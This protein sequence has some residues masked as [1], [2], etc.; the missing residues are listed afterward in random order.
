MGDEGGRRPSAA[1]SA[2][3]GG[4][5]ELPP[6]QGI[7]HRTPSPFPA[8]PQA[9]HLA[10]LH[11]HRAGPNSAMML[12]TFQPLFSLPL[13][14]EHLSP[15]Y[16]RSCSGCK[17]KI[18]KQHIF[19]PRENDSTA[20]KTEN[21]TELHNLLQKTICMRF[22]RLLQ[23]NASPQM[24]WFMTAHNTLVLCWGLKST[25]VALG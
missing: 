16:H 12:I 25:Q 11:T 15:L 14:P 3:R 2:L 23:C 18:W 4:D 6:Q 21:K 8:A 24:Y 19:P 7:L 22:L 10:S 20:I 13:S 1:L 9:P 17:G 5:T